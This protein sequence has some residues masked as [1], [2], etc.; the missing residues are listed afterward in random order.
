MNFP[1]VGNERL[2]AAIEKMLASRKVP[3]AILIEG[4]SGLGKTTL[5]DFLCAAVFCEGENPPCGVCTACRLFAGGNHPDLTVIEPEKDRKTIP[6]RAVRE[7]VAAAAIVPQKASRHIFLTDCAQCMTPEAQNAL[8]KVLEEPPEAAM[9]I[10]TCNSRAEL[11]TTVVSR[12]TVFTLGPVDREIAA[13]YI[14]SKVKREPEEIQA[15]VDGA[16][17]NIGAA[18]TILKS[19]SASAAEE[20]AKEFCDIMQNGSQYQM[21]KLLLPLE[22]SRP[23]TLDFYNALEIKLVS[24]I[25]AS[26]SKTLVSR[27]ERLYGTAIEHKTLLKSNANLSLLLTRLAAAAMTER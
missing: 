25:R 4:E 15:A 7:I 10:L 21:L 11:L 17:G 8:L 3:H 24:L 19:K 18:L 22:K 6:V 27:Y 12:C 14:S 13:E 9:F 2:K 5:A 23:K 26:R 20:K 16:Q 1:L